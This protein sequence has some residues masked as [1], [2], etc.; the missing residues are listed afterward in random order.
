[1]RT[2]IKLKLDKQEIALLKA[3]LEKYV[4]SLGGSVAR[5]TYH[6]QNRYV[7]GFI[8]QYCT[9]KRIGEVRIYA[10]G[11]AYAYTVPKNP[12]TTSKQIIDRQHFPELCFKEEY[13]ATI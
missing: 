12:R 8:C 9:D 4:A 13:N 2:R 3:G 5:I 7:R 1:M 11:A 10:E 6:K